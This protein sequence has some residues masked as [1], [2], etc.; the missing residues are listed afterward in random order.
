MFWDNIAGIYDVVERIYNNKVIEGT[1]AICADLMSEDDIVLE[2]ACGTGLITSAT[3]PITQSYTATDFSSKMLSKCRKK[4]KG[5][6]GIT[7]E[8]ADITSLRFTDASFDK[9]IAGNVIHLLDDP[10]KAMDELVRVTKPGG[11]I[12]VPTYLTKTDRA[13][14]GMVGLFNKAGANFK[15]LFDLDS[16]KAFFSDMGYTDVE[17]KVATGKMPCAVAIIRVL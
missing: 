12:I 2:C 5:V 16:Y 3:A 7:Y 6:S 8:I 15:S 9:V 13:H 17:Y 4:M 1:A 11:M 14:N 10:R